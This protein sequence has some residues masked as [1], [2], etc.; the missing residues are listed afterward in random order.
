[1][2]LEE[3]LKRLWQ[4]QFTGRRVVLKEASLFETLQREE[5]SFRLGLCAGDIGMV[6]LSGALLMVLGCLF[7]QAV[8]Q[9]PLPPAVRGPSLIWPALIL[10]L[11][12]TGLAVFITSDRFRYR[13][14]HPRPED[15]IRAF[16]ESFLALLDRRIQLF[17]S[18]FWWFVLPIIGIGDF[19]FRCYTAWWVATATGGP[20][21]S[22]QTV[23]G[24]L[25]ESALIGAAVYYLFRWHIKRHLQPRKEE[26]Q[27]LLLTLRS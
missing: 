1:M 5:R 9:P 16:A 17:K 15:S 20:H 13:R 8:R 18:V 25:L 19:G 6:L 10:G 11:P 12:L 24:A 7:Y 2:N 22:V 26:L 23:L 27:R 21:G 3:R 14:W 4:T